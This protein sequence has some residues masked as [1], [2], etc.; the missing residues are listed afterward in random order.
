[1]KAAVVPFVAQRVWER[2][3]LPA[4]YLRCADCDFGFFIP[5]MDENES[6]R[7]YRGY[8]DADYQRARFACEPWY[9]EDLNC[10]LNVQA[11]TLASRRSALIAAIEP[12]ISL[13]Q[14]GRVLDYG[15]G[16]G[17]LVQ[18][19]G[20]PFVYDP[21]GIETCGGVV[22]LS[23]PEK[24]APYDLIVCAQ[25]LEHVSSPMAVVHHL[26]SLS[27]RN[28]LLYVDV[29]TQNPASLKFRLNRCVQWLWLAVS[30]PAAAHALMG[31]LCWMHE[32]VN[33]FTMRSLEKLIKISGSFNV[34]CSGKH[35]VHHT[36]SAWALAVAL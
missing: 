9:T 14:F 23:N 15:G 7:L 32:H 8:R 24:H 20:E 13:R 10:E 17:R 1:M 18:G 27:Y 11:K 3:G 19:I 28:T 6:A 36:S 33:M 12:Y 35:P 31:T 34:L 25:V 5:R 29:P 4:E 16:D 21:S 2:D 30:R 22:A 26:R